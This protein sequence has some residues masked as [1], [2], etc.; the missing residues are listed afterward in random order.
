MKARRE[1]S[2]KLRV[3]FMSGLTV[4]LILLVALGPSSTAWAKLPKSLSSDIAKIAQQKSRGEDFAKRLKEA[5][6][7]KEIKKEP[8]E[9]GK[10]LYIEAKAAF[11]GLITKLI[12]DLKAGGK[13]E[14]SNEEK[15]LLQE[16][17]AKSEEFTNYV[18]KLL[19]GESRGAVEVA[20]IIKGIFDAL[21]PVVSKTW[22]EYREA[23]KQQKEEI[24]KELNDLRW[25]DF[26][27][28]K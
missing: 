1:S 18:D 13:A 17:I 19:Y 10:N 5:N 4:I 20:L 21:F 2:T 7:E 16:A 6:A 23:S 3:K 11:D 24:I 9:K 26:A 14:P 28:I 15:A 22:K 25:Q 27:K 8:F 12:M